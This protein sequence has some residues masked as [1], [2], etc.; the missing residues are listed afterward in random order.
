[1][2]RK[3]QFDTSN[4]EEDIEILIAF[5]YRIIEFSEYHFR[6]NDKLDIW[7]TQRKYFM[8][9]GHQAYSYHPQNLVEFVRDQFELSTAP[10]GNQ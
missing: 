6:V 1:M 7:P 3:S 5:D 10:T 9:G 2:S 4:V 8:H